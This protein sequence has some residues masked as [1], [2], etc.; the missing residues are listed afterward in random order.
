MKSILILAGVAAF[1]AAPLAAQSA[2]SHPAAPHTGAPHESGNA[3]VRELLAM[4]ERF[5]AQGDAETSRLLAQR[6]AELM[7]QA[8]QS[9]TDARIVLKD[10][11]FAHPTEPALLEGALLDLESLGG[12]SVQL[13]LSAAGD[14]QG[15]RQ[16]GYVTEGGSTQGD[17]L[18][19][20][21]DGV[22]IVAEQEPVAYEFRGWSNGT[23]PTQDGDVMGALREIRAELAA[24][25]AEIAGLRAQISG[26][27]PSGGIMIAPRHDGAA[28]PHG[29]GHALP[30]HPG[31]AGVWSA[32]HTMAAPEPPAPPAAPGAPQ[33]RH[34]RLRAGGAAPGE[35][36]GGVWVT[37]GAEPGAGAMVVTTPEGAWAIAPAPA[38]GA[39][40]QQA[41]VAAKRRH[42][43]DARARAE[44]QWMERSAAAADASSQVDAL[45]AELDAARA[46]IME[47]QKRLEQSGQPA[48]PAGGGH[49]P[50]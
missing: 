7:E 35:G 42:D 27:A 47:L 12:E 2:P 30:A 31:S 36:A 24:M 11:A 20:P 43:E 22:I 23:T 49:G 9:M 3:S 28:A 26:G 5:A 13:D 4:S 29:M 46:M 38:E 48:R 17:Y 37:P 34:Y 41:E 45:R 25:R 19:Y 50:W 44:V 14:L 32:P 6:A 21:Q 10:L 16:L 39:R 15:L 1:A 18:T 40:L 33:V 8:R